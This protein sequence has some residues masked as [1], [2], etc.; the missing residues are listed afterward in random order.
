MGE[1]LGELRLRKNIDP[2]VE[3]HPDG[4]TTES[5]I[6]IDSE[7][8]E[9]VESTRH[10]HPDGDLDYETKTRIALGSGERTGHLSR[11]YWP[12]GIIAHEDRTFIDRNTAEDVESVRDF[13]PDGNP[14][15]AAET[16]HKP[17]GEKDGG[18]YWLQTWGPGRILLL[19]G[20]NRFDA[21]ANQE[22]ILEKENFPDGSLKSVSEI[23]VDRE[24][25]SVVKTLVESYWQDKLN[26]AKE[27]SINLE[28]GKA[29]EIS[30][31]YR[32]D[33]S[34]SLESGKWTAPNDNESV[35]WIHHYS[36][37]GAITHGIAIRTD[38]KTN[39]KQV[40]PD[41]YT[42]AL[43]TQTTEQLATLGGT[44]SD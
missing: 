41:D 38:L 44:G 37:F 18:K 35:D 29:V 32:P 31:Q 42:E 25:G 13:Y 36:E 26:S 3:R 1:Q 16:R 14:Q 15:R 8:D 20:L 6:Y 34:V 40:M 23:R 30:R 9:T 10:R 39:E 24:T 12:D 5:T 22:I 4:S 43:A 28:T 11:R 19:E 2:E 21:E 7:T 27:E 33:G 17:G